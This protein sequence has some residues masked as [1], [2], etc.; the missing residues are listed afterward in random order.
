MTTSD[1][2]MRAGVTVTGDA[3]LWEWGPTIGPIDDLGQAHARVAAALVN[4]AGEP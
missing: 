1:T 2:D 3:F 4:L